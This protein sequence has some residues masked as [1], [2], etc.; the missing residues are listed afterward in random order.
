MKRSQ[1]NFLGFKNNP[2]CIK[3]R[4]TYIAA[5]V[6]HYLKLTIKVEFLFRFN[7]AFDIQ[8]NLKKIGFP[9]TILAYLDWMPEANKFFFDLRCLQISTVFLFVMGCSSVSLRYLPWTEQQSIQIK[10]CYNLEDKCG[11]M[12]F[13]LFKS[14]KTQNPCFC[15]KSIWIGQVLQF[16]KLKTAV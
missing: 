2:E 15:F 1:L 6:K 9:F 16:F 10:T 8:I 5:R 11:V 4:T 13:I 12:H 7:N 14:T 3:M